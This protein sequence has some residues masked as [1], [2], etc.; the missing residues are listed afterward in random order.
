MIRKEVFRIDTGFR[1]IGNGI[2]EVVLR[3]NRWNDSEEIASTSENKEEGNLA[4]DDL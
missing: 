2:D 1:E 4:K 3:I